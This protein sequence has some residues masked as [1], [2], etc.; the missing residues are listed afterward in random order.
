MISREKVCSVVRL[1]TIRLDRDLADARLLHRADRIDDLLARAG[2]RGCAN[3]P[4]RH[5]RLVFLAEAAQVPRVEFEMARLG[6]FV[7][8]LVSGG[9]LRDVVAQVRGQVAPVGRGQREDV[10]RRGD[11]RPHGAPHRGRFEFLARARQMKGGHA[12]RADARELAS[13]TLGAGAHAIHHEV[14]AARA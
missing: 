13:R 1:S 3:H 7:L 9:E 6:G 14:K 11:E 4:L 2:K 5:Q 10:Q 12:E 8:D